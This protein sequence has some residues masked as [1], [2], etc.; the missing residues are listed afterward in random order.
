MHRIKG[1]FIQR[2]EYK[3]KGAE[4]GLKKLLEVQR[5]TISRCAGRA[6]RMGVSMRLRASR[7]ANT[8]CH[9]TWPRNHRALEAG[10]LPGYQF[11]QYYSR[12]MVMIVPYKAGRIIGHRLNGLPVFIQSLLYCERRKEGSHGNKNLQ[13]KVRWSR[14]HKCNQWLLT[15]FSAK[16]FPGH[17]LCSTPHY[18]SGET[19]EYKPTHLRPNPKAIFLAWIGSFSLFPAPVSHL[20][21]SNLSGLGYSAAFFDMDLYQELI[22]VW[23][24]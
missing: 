5:K 10:N 9:L 23:K 12:S 11:K 17:I 4:R 16:S 20:S 13:T 2:C 14:G 15:A 21:G 18:L 8:L 3:E 6:G 19:S 24:S 7:M 1:V 22:S